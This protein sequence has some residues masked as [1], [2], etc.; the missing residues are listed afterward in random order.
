MRT[1]HLDAGRE[2]RGGQW[3][4][5]RL[6]GGLKHAGIE[7]ILLC[8]SGSPLWRE[9]VT[10]GYD[11]QPLGW[12]SVARIS[13]RVDLTHAHDARSHTWAA[14]LARPPFVVSRRV[15]FPIGSRWKYAR[16]ASYLAVSECVKRVLI[17][18]GVSPERIDVVYDGVPL[19]T[20]TT[21]GDR[22]VA[23]AT[24]DPRK[25]SDLLQ[26]AARLAGISVHFSRNLE[27][28]LH[29]A[30]LFVYL[31]RSEGLGSGVL[32]AMA[33]GVP[34]LASRV[35]GLPEIITHDENG[36]LT[37][38]DPAEIA[39][40]LRRLTADRGLRQRL[41]ERARRTIEERFSVEAMVRGTLQVY[42]K[43]V[44]C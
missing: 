13:R 29:G 8:P 12:A 11:V 33:A 4:V 14:L 23:P 44:S 30:A 21:L 15:A 36:W 19:C 1:L 6:I 32:L 40:A 42:R 16:P 28:D 39:T 37:E 10:Q 41:A 17:A 25:G 35:G 20:P 43:V 7:S 24:T 34:V 5:I 22:I 18:G 3:Q 38:N 26:T 31:T 27:S 2:M 9:A